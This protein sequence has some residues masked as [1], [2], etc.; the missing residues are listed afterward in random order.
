VPQIGGKITE[1]FKIL[2]SFLFHRLALYG[3]ETGREHIFVKSRE[4]E[5]PVRAMQKCG[6]VEV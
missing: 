3:L 4:G 5:V 1:L 6:G 2:S